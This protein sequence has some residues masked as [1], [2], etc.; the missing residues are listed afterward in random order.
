MSVVGCSEGDLL[1]S[2]I[3]S[4]RISIL[5]S[6]IIN[7]WSQG[8][9]FCILSITELQHCPD[10]VSGDRY[11]RPLVICC[12]VT[13]TIYTYSKLLYI[14]IR[15]IS[16]PHAV[17]RVSNG[18]SALSGARPRGLYHRIP[19]LRCTNHSDYF[20]LCAVLLRALTSSQCVDKPFCSEALPWRKDAADE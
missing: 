13:L 10:M 12:P 7:G 11:V 6:C 16:T 18:P 5:L 17:S 8:F 15:F 9:H 19:A 14:S 3:I 2:L 4:S 1:N 20:F